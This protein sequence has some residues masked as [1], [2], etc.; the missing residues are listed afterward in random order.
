MSMD[1]TSATAVT[2]LLVIGDADAEACV[3]GFC[4]VPPAKTA[5]I[6]PEQRGTGE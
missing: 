4:A 5:E 6:S 1:E 3:D 2:P